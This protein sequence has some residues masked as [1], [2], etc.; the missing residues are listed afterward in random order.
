VAGVQ[1]LLDKFELILQMGYT[2]ACFSLK[3]R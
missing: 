2:V 3:V 1:N